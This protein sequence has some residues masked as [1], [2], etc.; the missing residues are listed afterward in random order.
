[1]LTDDRRFKVRVNGVWTGRDGHGFVNTPEDLLE[2]IRRFNP[3]MTKVNLMGKPRWMRAETD[4][5]QKEYS[6]I[7][8]EFARED[9]AKAMLAARYIAMYTKFC[10]VVHHADR[11][12]VLQ[13]SKCWS[14]GHHASKCRNPTKCRKCAGAHSEADHGG[15]AAQKAGAAEGR[16]DEDNLVSL[17]DIPKCA[18]CGGEHPATE[19]NCPERK[20][21]QML[22]REK[23]EDAMEGGRPVR[24]RKG[25][26]K[27]NTGRAIGAEGWSE[28]QN[29]GGRTTPGP[30]NANN[31]D[32]D[33]RERQAETTNTTNKYMALENLLNQ[34]EEDFWAEMDIE[35]SG[36]VTT[37]A[38]G[39]VQSL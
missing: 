10:E 24:K 1:M 16:M 26:K 25:A 15:V 30:V 36:G 33:T 27:T 20:R 28:P 3:I 19:R 13:C 31:A 18:N 8:L 21:Y 4:L 35:M 5:R 34:Q 37:N 11:P 2:E 38:S 14:L 17:E 39:N 29:G 23:D 22:T 7:V 32:K 6:S 12:P 9:D